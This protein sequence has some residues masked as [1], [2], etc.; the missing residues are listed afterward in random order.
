MN[1]LNIFT[2]YKGRSVLSIHLFN[3]LIIFEIY[4]AGDKIVN[5]LNENWKHFTSHFGM[6]F[7]KA[8]MEIFYERFTKFFEGVPTKY[9]FIEDLTKYVKET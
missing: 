7:T 9:L 2:L 1:I 6:E 8:T 5:Y 3:V 4:L